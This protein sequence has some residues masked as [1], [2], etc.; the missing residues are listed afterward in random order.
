MI[1]ENALNIKIANEYR[2]ERKA[3][4]EAAQEE[5]FIR[6]LIRDGK[7]RTAGEYYRRIAA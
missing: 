5:R 3:Q 1:S 7:I 6:Q 4:E 2:A